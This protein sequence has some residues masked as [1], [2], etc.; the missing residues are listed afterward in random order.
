M[1]ANS[2]TGNGSDLLLLSPAA[3]AAGKSRKHFHRLY[4]RRLVPPPIMT[5]PLCRWSRRQ[6]ELWTQGAIQANENGVWYEWD[7]GQEIWRKLPNQ[8][9]N[10]LPADAA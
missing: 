3:Q 1:T 6:L 9:V 2:N 10:N 5:A 4:Q 8:Y 7:A